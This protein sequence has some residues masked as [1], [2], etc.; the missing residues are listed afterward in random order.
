MT[1]FQKED[2]EMK[3]LV[4]EIEQKNAFSRM[5]ENVGN[6]KCKPLLTNTFNVVH[7]L[8]V[9][10]GMKIENSVIRMSN[11]FPLFWSFSIIRRFINMNH[12]V[13]TES[14]FINLK[15]VTAFIDL[16]A[17]IG[18]L[19]AIIWVPLATIPDLLPNL[20]RYYPFSILFDCFSAFNA[21]S[22]L[23]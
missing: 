13:L 23:V 22:K 14:K 3:N 19:I 18:M 21:G 6:F 11:L 17:N 16:C 9:W 7:L 2:I 1:D 8:I 15:F 20:E 12:V 5:K 10:M 4:E